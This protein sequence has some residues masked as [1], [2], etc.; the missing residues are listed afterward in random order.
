MLTKSL[1]NYITIQENTSDISLTDQMSFICRY[2]VVKDKEVEVRESYLVFFHW[3]WGKADDIKKMILD[4]LERKKLDFK[5]FWWIGFNNAASITGVHDDIQR[6]SRNIN[7]KTRFVP[8][9]NPVGNLCSVHA[10][11][12][13]ASAITFFWVIETQYI[14][15]LFQSLVGSF[16][17]ACKG[18]LIVDLTSLVCD[19]DWWLSGRVSALNSVVAG[20]ISSGGNHGI[21]CWWGLIRSKKLSSVSVYCVQVFAGISGHGNSIHKVWGNGN[22][23][24]NVY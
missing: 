10:S 16:F 14:F 18:K 20:L 21:H 12:M 4:R 8:C 24:W 13:N 1:H 9:S 5:D 2:V 22:F 23:S 17:F 11:A 7:G 15:L 19:D 3:A 6:F